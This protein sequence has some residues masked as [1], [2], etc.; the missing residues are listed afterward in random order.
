MR[1]LHRGF[2]NEDWRG[3]ICSGSQ[4]APRKYISACKFKVKFSKDNWASKIGREGN[5]LAQREM[6]EERGAETGGNSAGR[7]V[8]SRRRRVQVVSRRCHS[9]Q[10]QEPQASNA[11]K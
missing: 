4:F 9:R 2:E 10:R 1:Q 3:R 11:S 7:R 6:L 5:S 8:G